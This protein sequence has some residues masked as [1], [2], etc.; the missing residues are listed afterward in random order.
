[1]PSG[2]LCLP[3]GCERCGTLHSRTRAA[4]AGR[5]EMASSNG[6]FEGAA[7]LAFDPAPEK[8]LS[9]EVLRQPISKDLSEPV[10]ARLNPPPCMTCSETEVMKN[11]GDVIRPYFAFCAVINGVCYKTGLGK[12]KKESK[13]N[14]AKLALAELLNLENTG[15]KSFEDSDFPCAP[16]EPRPPGNSA[17]VSRTGERIYQKLSQMLEEVFNR[18]TTQHPEY[19]SCGSSLAAFI[20][21]KGGQHEVVALGTGECNYSR[22]FESCGR[23]LHDSHAVVTARRSLLRY[24]YRHLLLF[25]NK[26]PAKAE[27]SIFCTA[28]GSKLLTLKQNITLSLYMN[29]LPKGTAQLKSEVHLGPQSIS[30]YEASEELSLHVALEGRIYL[31]VC[32]PP[33][34]VRVSS[35]SSGDKLTKWEVVGLQGALLSH[36]IEPVYISNILVGNG[37]C[38]DTKGLDITIKQ[39]LDDELISKLPV[40]YLVN[41]SHIYLVKAALPIQTY[42]N[43]WSLSLNWTLSDAS[44]EVVDGLSGKTTESSPFRSGTCLASRLCKAAMF[45][46]FRMLAREAGRGDLLQF[47]TYHEA[48]VKSQLYQEAKSLLQSY[49]EQHSYGSWIVKSPHIEQFSD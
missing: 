20:I 16:D 2:V 18:L 23:L 32:C 8:I 9:P 33:K 11:P 10:T 29:Q 13:L 30:A 25:Y 7:M 19:Q 21:E 34:T 31:A 12:N 17:C 36:F 39:R 15:A 24:L 14:A 41:R 43:Q 38:K 44:L 37:I 22:R 3:A 5:S 4:G 1:M 49:L 42:L 27:R 47:A 28:P 45:S 48:K 35:M 40:H 6:C 26:N 46:R